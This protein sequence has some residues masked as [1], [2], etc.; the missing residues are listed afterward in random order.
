[1]ADCIV[2]ISEEDSHVASLE[3]RASPSTESQVG[4]PATPTTVATNITTASSPKPSKVHRWYFVEST[5]EGSAKDLTLTL[6]EERQPPVKIDAS[7]DKTTWSIPLPSDHEE[8]EFCDIVL[9]VSVQDL[10]IDCIESIL[11]QIEHQTQYGGYEN[12]VIRANELKQLAL[13]DSQDENTKTE[14]HKQENEK[15]DTIFLWKLFYRFYGIQGGATVALAVNTWTDLLREYGSLN[16]HFVELCADSSIRYRADPLY[17]EHHPH[18]SWLVDL[19]RSGCPD[20]DARTK[21]V[22]SFVSYSFSG[23]GRFAA[24]KT[25]VGAENYLEVWDLTD[26][27]EAASVSTTPKKTVYP[28]TTDESEG[29]SQENIKQYRATPV[30]WM[31]LSDRDSDISIS[32]DGSMLAFMDRVHPSTNTDSNESSTTA[33]E[34][35]FAIYR[36][37]LDHSNAS[38][39]SSS[40]MSLVRHDVPRK[41]PR[42]KNFF[43]EGIFHMVDKSKPDLKDELFVTCDRI[44]VDVYNAFETWTHVRSIVLNSAVTS[45]DL[46][47]SIESTSLGHLQGRYFIT[48]DSDTVY[49]FDILQGALVAFTSSLSPEE[50]RILDCFA[51]LSEDGTFIAIAEYHKVSI[52]RTRTWTL[53]G[54][55]MFYEVGSDERVGGVSFI[56]KGKLLLVAIGPNENT[57]R[58]SRP[59]YLLDIATMS[60]VDRVAPD[61]YAAFYRV[62]LSGSEQG[63]IYISYSQ[64]W[65]VRLEDRTYQYGERLPDRCTDLCKSP[66]CRDSGVQEGTSSTG[67]HFKAE[68]TDASIL[69]HLSRDKRATL[70][71][72]MTEENSSRVK[73]MVIPL[74][75][76]VSI[77]SAA[78]FADFKY[79]LV[80]T[81][82]T[83]MGW[84]V[85]TTFDG[86]FRLLLAL[87]APYI[88]EWILCPH[89]FIRCRVEED[90]EEFKFFGHIKHPF[91]E[92]E[93]L[94]NIYLGVVAMTEIYEFADPRLKQD[95]LRF[96]SRYLNRYFDNGQWSVLLFLFHHWSPARHYICYDFLKNLLALPGSPWIPSQEMTV[97][98]SPLASVLSI[99]RTQP[100]AIGLAQILVE[101]CIQQAKR[102]QDQ[103]FLVPIRQCLDLIVDP[104][105]Q[106][107]EL[108]TYVYREMAYF[109]VEGRDFIIGHHALADPVIFRWAFWK[110]CPWGLQQ[111]KDQVMQL[112]TTKIP[113]P[114]KGNFTRELYLAS[115][116][117]LWR[118]TYADIFES[119]SDKEDKVASEPALFSWS[120]AI[121]AMV[122]RK[123]R[124]RHNTSVECY[125]F[126]NETLGNP[127]LMAL[128]EY[129]WNTIGFNYWM[130]RFLGQL[131]YYALVLTAIFLQIDGANR[132]EEKGAL[133]S[134]SSPEG[135][136]IAIIAVAFIF[137]WLE[138][139]QLA[140]D[141]ETYIRSIYNWVDL[142]VFLL[143]LAGAINQILIIHNVVVQGLNPGLLSFSVL[144]IFLHFGGSYDQVEGGFT[145]NSFAFHMLMMVFFFF[146]VILMLNVLI[147]L[148]NNAINDGDQTWQL[149]WMDYRMRYV[150]SA[151][152]MTYDIPGFRDNNKFFPDTIFYTAATQKVRDFAKETQKRTNE[153][154][155]TGTD[156]VMTVSASVAT[157]VEPDTTNSSPSVGDQQQQHQKSATVVAS[158]AVTATV[159]GSELVAP[160]KTP[161]G[162]RGGGGEDALM[163][164]LLR[165]QEDLTKREEAQLHRYE[166]QMKL[167]A[168]QSKRLEEQYLALVDLQTELR[169]LRQSAGRSDQ[170]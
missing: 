142:F 134:D 21:K 30:A 101:Y 98:N 143:P 96:Y 61:G 10:K 29:S 87:H 70:T 85:P 163:S 131:C 138:I 92:H 139:L 35:E 120:R 18:L 60:V 75:D 155:L 68:K 106:F 100:L 159:T 45:M 93:L 127:A 165:Q 7:R 25:F 97:L 132:A 73:T 4:L 166:E 76:G 62:A 77:C 167:M 64:L 6:D 157:I 146:T 99:A 122:L 110:P 118:K 88:Q 112:E 102:R 51:C 20:Y 32:W 116:D 170:Q 113:R 162:G 104:K 150:E 55:Y 42:L 78:F 54:S 169:S 22:K 152:N 125:P 24:L 56:C 121:W 58:Q 130:V 71:V 57:F 33:Y 44:M 28:L 82:A 107:S 119:E 135:L 74:P 26:R 38:E 109:P 46:A 39:K 164:L 5:A 158:A 3:V 89:G 13:R 129:K 84:T 128:V 48:R 34:S 90:D 168:E 114:T 141:K 153:A 41:C 136:F 140:K 36:C 115:F 126:E 17:R 8:G 9:G 37:S 52:Y 15:D 2:N 147:A 156:T 149:D 105:Q 63:L 31:P 111:Y 144:F 11:L 80:V 19:S 69:S 148:I 108:A 16:L 67:L 50:L 49:T 72:T 160:L 12:E 14:T 94:Q 27:E 59:G 47:P 81:N 151:E 1:M 43:G 83:N 161:A 23:D 40:R 154:E 145:S 79:L 65:I 103:Y 133:I 117:M 123:C 66:E 91:L 86:N 95:I 137:L 124:L 53:H